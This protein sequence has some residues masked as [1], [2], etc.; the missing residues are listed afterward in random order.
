M[1]FPSEIDLGRCVRLPRLYFVSIGFRYDDRGN[2]RSLAYAAGR[3]LERR[4]RD[5][6]GR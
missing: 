6:F 5:D 1:E 3:N 4:N 2:R